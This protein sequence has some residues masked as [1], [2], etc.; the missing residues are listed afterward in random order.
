MRWLLKNEGSIPSI[1]K[2][3]FVLNLLIEVLIVD[4]KENITRFSNGKFY[5]FNC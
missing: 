5:C 4:S 1:L 3:Y 2:L